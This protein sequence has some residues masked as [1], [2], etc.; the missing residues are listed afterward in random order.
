M[1]TIVT[2]KSW[3]HYG[4]ILQNEGILHVPET[5][6]EEKET[7][8]M[9]TPSS[10]IP[11]NQKQTSKDEHPL[12]DYRMITQTRNFVGCKMDKFLTQHSKGGLVFTAWEKA[13]HIFVRSRKIFIVLFLKVVFHSRTNHSNR[14][15][16]KEK[17]QSIPVIK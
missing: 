12:I 4:N 15:C 14:E 1:V 13:F 11:I 16:D 10:A 9:H 7:D 2:S 8:N 6:F 5:T 17:F 3:Q